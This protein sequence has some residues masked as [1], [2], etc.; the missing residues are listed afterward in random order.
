MELVRP[1]MEPSPLVIIAGAQRF[2]P[3]I[4][5]AI[6]RAELT[7]PFAM[8][9]AGW[10]EREPDDGEL[11]DHLGVE[12]YN[13]ELYRRA[14][15]VMRRD[16]ALREA[17]RQ[18]QARLQ[19]RQDFYRIRLEHQLKAAEVIATRAASDRL[20]EEAQSSSVEAVQQLDTW[21]LSKCRRDLEQFESEWLPLER[22][23]VAE[24][25]EELKEIIGKCHAVAIAGGHVAALLNRLELFGMR[26]L[27]AG[28]PIVAW[29]A[30]AMAITER[31]VLYHDFS[32]QGYRASEV[33]AWGLGALPRVVALPQPESRL[34]RD[35]ES[36]IRVMA[37][38]FAPAHCIGLPAR[39]SAIFRHST[40]Q[41][42]AGVWSLD[43]DGSVER[44]GA[45]RGVE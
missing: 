3:T 6:Q 33:L 15:D 23:A 32:P 17:H 38:R 37:Q 35:D 41:N 29:S 27:L 31:V 19:R 5:Q 36:R 21:H 30:G 2:N 20:H 8:I 22:E 16:P 1:K 40:I 10:R 14:D 9:T 25:R 44:L 4:G 18:R 45:V 42:E 12:T 24:Q 7:G 43:S 34:N 13:L 28:K 26:E 39:S 11:R